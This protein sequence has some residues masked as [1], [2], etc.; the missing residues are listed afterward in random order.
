LIGMDLVRLGLERARTAADALDVVTTLLTEHGQGGS[1]EDGHDDPYF[2]S[3]LI[4]DPTG[5]WVLET[6]AR[7][8]AARSVEDGAAI[9][10]RVSLR[11]EWTRASADVAPGT[12]FDAWRDP[13]APTGIADHRLRATT[14]AVA[15][16]RPARPRSDHATSSRCSAT[17]APVRGAH[18]VR[19]P[20]TSSRCR[21]GSTP[22]GTV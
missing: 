1:C 14:S 22:T 9:S 7:T 19:R 6:S 10:N 16:W 21:P 20:P 3:F 13:G 2:S 8:W 18:R 12:D 4:A 11:T 15:P 5:A 17:T